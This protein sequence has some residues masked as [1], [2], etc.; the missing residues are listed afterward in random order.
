MG[1]TWGQRQDEATARK[2][3]FTVLGI[4]WPDS[5]WIVSSVWV[6]L[7]LGSMGLKLGLTFC[8][9]QV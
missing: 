2:I 5:K 8:A 3:D 4:G 9:I 7:L 6:C 1:Y